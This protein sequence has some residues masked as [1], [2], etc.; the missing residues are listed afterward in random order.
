MARSRDRHRLN[1]DRLRWRI[2]DR[3]RVARSVA[4][5]LQRRC[6]KALAR[7]TGYKMRVVADALR[8]LCDCK[9]FL[10]KDKGFFNPI[11]D[12]IL[13]ERKSKIVA[14]RRLA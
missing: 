10:L 3:A 7:R 11:A 4:Q 1:D 14:K 9:R 6:T 8:K 5:V 2:G 13:E 12:P